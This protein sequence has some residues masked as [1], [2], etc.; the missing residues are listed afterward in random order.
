MKPHMLLSLGVVCA[1]GL[2]SGCSG[3]DSAPIISSTGTTASAS[4][5]RTPQSEALTAQEAALVS[6]GNSEP[7]QVPQPDL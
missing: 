2:L 1:A 5:Q 4:D 7:I 3:S 6:Q